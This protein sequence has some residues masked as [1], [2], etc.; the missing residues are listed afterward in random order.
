MLLE[1]ETEKRREEISR[2]IKPNSI[3][4]AHP[5]NTYNTDLEKVLVEI[6]KLGFP[7]YTLE[8]PNQQYHQ[9]N[10][11]FWKENFGN[12]MK[13]YFE[14]ILP[15][16]SAG[17]GLPFEDGMYG[18]GIFGELKMLSEMGK[19]IWRI[20]WNGGIREIEKLN[21]ELALS[22]GDTKKRVYQ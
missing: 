18:A 6:I 22:V 17:I 5:I 19:P 1:E 13:Y 2:L 12:G 15:K 10:Y 11:K 14:E 4:F 9:E 8:N 20:S 21:P 3:Y 16:M 7:R